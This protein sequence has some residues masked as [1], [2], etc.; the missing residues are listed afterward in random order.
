MRT[1]SDQCSHVDLKKK[2]S[3]NNEKKRFLPKYSKQKPIVAHG[4]ALCAES[5]L[6]FDS[7]LSQTFSNGFKPEGNKLV[8]IIFFLCQQF[9]LP[10]WNKVMLWILN[11]NCD[12]P[13]RGYHIL[14]IMG[15]S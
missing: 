7:W 5:L 11:S 13:N 15:I 8:A 4:K 3:S 14:Q 6:I 2:L 12:D 10:S 9:L 1:S